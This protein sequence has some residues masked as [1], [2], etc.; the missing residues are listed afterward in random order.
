MEG[1]SAAVWDCRGWWLARWH[2]PRRRGWRVCVG[3]RWAPAVARPSGTGSSG[4]TSAARFRRSSAGNVVDWVVVAVQRDEVRPCISA[5]VTAGRVGLLS[6]R[7][8]GSS[9]LELCV[10][11]RYS[12][13]LGRAWLAMT[14]AQSPTLPMAWATRQLC[15]GRAAWASGWQC[16]PAPESSAAAAPLA[17]LAALASGA[18][19]DVRVRTS[20]VALGSTW[21][22]T[23][24]VASAPEAQWQEY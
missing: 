5:A 8:L 3:G 16:G 6:R 1:A 12:S 18:S 2:P 23:A 13:A 9:W 17:W 11:Q 21:V 4:G 7:G 24:S 14:V 20:A 22:A 15:A 10:R 19:G